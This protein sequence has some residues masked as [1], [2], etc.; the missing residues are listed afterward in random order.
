MAR[1][2]DVQRTDVRHDDAQGRDPRAEPGSVHQHRDVVQTDRRIGRTSAS[3]EP[4]RAGR[5]AR[6]WGRF[7]LP[8]R[9]AGWRARASALLAQKCDFSR[10][11]DKAPRRAL[12]SHLAARIVMHASLLSARTALA[13]APR[14]SRVSARASRRACT[15]APRAMSAS[16]ICPRRTST[17]TTSPSPSSAARWCSSPTSRASEA[18]RAPTTRI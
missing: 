17:A 6:V 5:R 14:T 9:R 3:P 16:T 7:P 4:R 10:L 18:R 1:G 8:R 11:A 2:P 12:A 13:Q 15:V